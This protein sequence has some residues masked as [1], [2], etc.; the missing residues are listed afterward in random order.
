MK[1][2]I[3]L[4]S[5]LSL[6]S[7][8]ANPEPADLGGNLSYLRVHSLAD[9]APVLHSALSAKHALVLDLRYTTASEESAGALRSDLAQHPAD[10]PLFILISPATPPGVLGAIHQSSTAFITLGVAGSQPA[11]KITVKMDAETDRRAYD[12]LDA[13]TA[14]EALTSGKIEKER[15]DEAILV[16]EFKN[17]NPEAAPPAAPDPTAVKPTEATDKPAPL[18]DR[19]LQRAVH[20]HQALL[21]LHR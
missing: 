8:A 13:G 21:A 12:A 14:V 2:L 15:F 4:F 3:L 9:A 5:V 10:V 6:Y 18:I 1:R 19:V 11:P 17:G 7:Y 16:Q 20:L